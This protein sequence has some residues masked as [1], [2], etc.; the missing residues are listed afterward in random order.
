VLPE[1]E[2]SFQH[3]LTQETVYQNILRRRRALFHRQVAE[4]M[5]A[6][7]RDN[8]DEFHEQLA[9]HYERSEAHEKA[10]EYLLKAGEK[11]RRAYLNEAAIDYFRRAL[12]RLELLSP[13]RTRQK[14][15]LAALRGLG[16]T[17]TD[18]AQATE[19]EEPLRRA[20]ALAGEMDLD[21]RT[22]ARLYWWLGE[23]L[24]WQDRYDEMAHLGEQGLAV[25]DDDARSVEAALMHTL[26]AGGYQWAGKVAEQREHRQ[27]IV[28]LLPGLPYIEELRDAYGQVIMDHIVEKRVEEAQ[29]WVA[30]FEQA[31]QQYH[32][33]SAL[34]ELHAVCIPNLLY[35]TGDVRGTVAELQAAVDIFGKIGAAG[36]ARVSLLYMAFMLLWLGELEPTDERLRGI[37]D[38]AAD[39]LKQDVLGLTHMALGLT[40]LCRA[41]PR[42]G[43]EALERAT[44]L[45]HGEPHLH[46]A[47][48]RAH[49]AQG[50]SLEARANFETATTFAMGREPFGWVMTAA[51]FLMAAGL[52]GLDEVAET[53]ES[54]RALVDRLRAEHPDAVNPLPAQSW[55]ERA[56]AQT[57]TQLRLHEAFAEA[58][59]PAW[60]WQDPFTDCSYAVQQGLH[61]QAANGRGL[62]HVNLSAPRL[63]RPA[64]SGDLAVQA[65]CRP[66]SAE[67]PAIGGLL[68]WKDRENYLVLER[69]LVGPADICFRGCLGNKDLL[70]GRGRLPAE[71]LSLRL[72][73]RG[74]R[75]RALCSADGASWLS[76]G[77]VEFP[78]ADPVEVGVHAIGCIDR[79]IY[80][81]AYPGGA[82]LR[83]DSFE[84][85]E[86]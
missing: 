12:A 77:S 45:V 64:P 79:A 30:I 35:M 46:V 18:A 28:H 40:L 19:A 75:V 71:R 24:W 84:V 21:S 49:V 55:L 15:E 13:G 4:A 70:I 9:H 80:H 83:F 39:G 47:L 78:V 33:L 43:T 69:G 2:Y 41:R 63:L 52:G 74:G 38:S 53:P 60:T 16:Q 62:W 73:R 59:A 81:G 6:L 8:L 57:F 11:S 1:Q 27:H 32:D 76:V 65:V 29:R 86:A 54:F 68:L 17:Y 72:E 44:R 26:A 51:S 48:G 58:L 5:E 22:I 7:Y 66:V 14:W 56:E 31:A 25:L 3:V 34:G 10:V 23:A 36:R 37:L 20:I 67:Q 85:W 82:A 61:L 42:E 50:R